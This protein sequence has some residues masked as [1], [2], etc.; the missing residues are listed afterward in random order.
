VTR[1]EVRVQRHVARVVGL[2]LTLATAASAQTAVPDTAA[3]R[4]VGREITVEGTVAR[5]KPSRHQQ[6]TFLNFGRD[7]PD[8]TFSVW[9]PDSVSARFGGDSALA[10]LVGKSVRARGTVWLQDGKWPAMTIL[11]PSRLVVL[12]NR[13]P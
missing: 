1:T 13:S 9:I 5:V 12:P 7:Y 4:Y 6:T 8:Q 2:M 3:A 10:P 11:E